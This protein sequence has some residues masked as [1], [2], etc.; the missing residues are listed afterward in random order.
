MLRS[1]IYSGASNRSN[2]SS[3]FRKD[4]I[5][6]TAACKLKEVTPGRG[7]NPAILYRF[8]SRILFLAIRE[9]MTHSTNSSMIKELPRLATI[10]PISTVNRAVSIAAEIVPSANNR[11]RKE[12]M[13]LRSA[14]LRTVSGIG[15]STYIG[16]ETY[17]FYT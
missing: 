5:N 10:Q 15:D 13:V 14:G 7:M 4:R 3:G 9:E 2:T 1:Q 6:S 12:R 16:R 11:Q 8:F 17:G